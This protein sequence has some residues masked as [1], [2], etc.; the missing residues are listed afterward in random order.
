MRGFLLHPTYRIRDGRPVVQLWGT[1]E[2][3]QPFLIEDDRRRPFFYVRSE[4]AK[5]F[6]GKSGV[7]V[8]EGGWRDLSGAPLSRIEAQLPGEVPDLRRHAE[9]RG[10]AAYEADVRFA[11]RYLIDHELRAALEIEGEPQSRGAGLQYFHNPSVR[12]ARYHPALRVLSIDIETT[13]DA[14][15]LLSFALVGAGADEVHLIADRAPPGAQAHADEAALLRAFVE[16]VVALDPDVITGWNVIDFDLRVLAERAAARR[17]DFAIGRGRERLRVQRDASYTR[18]SRADLPGRQVLDGLALVRDAGIALENYRLETAG[19]VLLG[20]GKKIEKPGVGRADEILRLYREEPEAFVAYNR[21]DS[22]L[23]LDI[24]ES[25]GLLEGVIARSLLSGMPLDRVG[26]S[27]ASFDLLVL[28]ELARRGYAAPSVAQDRKAA[29]LPGGAVLDS[30]PGFFRNVAV[31]DFKSLYPSLIRTFNLDPLAYAQADTDSDPIVTPNGARFARGEAVL[32]GILDDFAC[33]REQA[34]QRGDRHANQA[35]KIM[36][37]ALYGV[38]G[39]GS[40][41]FFEPEIASAITGTGQQMLGWTREIFEGFGQRVLY[42][43]TDSVFVALDPE[44][45]E[46]AAKEQAQVLLPRVQQAIAERVRDEYRVEPQLELELEKVYARFFQ[47]SVRG[48][49]T[50][51]KKR[52]AG[53][54]DGKLQVVGLEAVRRDWPEAARRLQCEILERVFCGEAGLPVARR[55]VDALRAGELDRELVIHKGLRKGSV[56]KYTERRPPHVEAARRAGRDV[57]RTVAYVIT[58]GGPEPVL[59]ERE[60]PRDI[61]REHY[62]EKVLRPIAEAIFQHTG[63]S[64]DAATGQGEQLSLL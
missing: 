38:L 11:Y 49:T 1:L 48:G 20:R 15:S 21:E 60:F 54:H 8:E 5:L 33:S 42:G 4:N 22:Q 57:G 18:T 59:P 47:P 3:G 56:D 28:P 27:I 50:G 43:D 30:S 34:K 9:N 26:A 46:A 36:M 2:S 39:A 40:C 58:H 19:Q 44:R 24:L 55:F 37:N 52:Y 25:Q 17:I 63:E 51:S 61:D 14:R 7:N 41:R 53:W 16:R 13:P 64:F 23:V 10:A 35:I 45:E 32:P 29:R 62:V 12:P 6:E 31:F